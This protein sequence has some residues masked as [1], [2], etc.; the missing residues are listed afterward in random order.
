M[1]G[2]ALMRGERNTSTAL[3]RHQFLLPL[4]FLLVFMKPRKGW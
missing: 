1:E 4:S 3:R 2:M